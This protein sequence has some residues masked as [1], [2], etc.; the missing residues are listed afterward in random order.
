MPLTA[1]E[2]ER[3]HNQ[4]EARKEWDRAKAKL[5]K[6]Q[7]EAVEAVAAVMALEVGEE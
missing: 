5:L 3:R 7:A 6:A 2:W 4:R 1:D